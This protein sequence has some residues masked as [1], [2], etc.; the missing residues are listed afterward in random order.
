MCLR[1]LVLEPLG[2]YGAPYFA[3]FSLAKRVKA[4][5]F[6]RLIL[7]RVF[8]M[9]VCISEDIVLLCSPE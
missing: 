7:S 1:Y 5:C 9:H 6:K 2:P 4:A 3:K 8:L